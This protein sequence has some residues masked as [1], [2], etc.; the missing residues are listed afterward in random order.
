[1][2]SA[3]L[4]GIPFELFEYLRDQ[5]LTCGTQS[6]YSLTA[7]DGIRCFVQQNIHL[8][9]LDLRGV[10]ANSR[11]SLIHSL[12]H[13]KFAPILTLID[14][15]ELEARAQM[16]DLGADCCLPGSTPPLLIWK[17]AFSLIR[18]YT[19]YN[20]YEQPEGIESAAFQVGDVYIDPLR[21][22]VEVSGK[23]VSLRPREFALLLYFMSNP[24]I[25]L[26]AEQICDKAWGVEGSY[27]RGVGQPIG[28]LRKAI[29]PDPSNPTYIETVYGV[30]YRFTGH[31]SES[32]DSL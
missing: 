17:S 22:I 27:G 1:M 3:L 21:R 6:L 8:L 26:T 5:L 9:L 24:Q 32:C 10:Q 23:C 11:T 28:E 12:R 19:A 31:A 18:R 15:N 25:V 30:G 2:K 13:T 16:F 20:H 7:T 4:V 14:D 29:E